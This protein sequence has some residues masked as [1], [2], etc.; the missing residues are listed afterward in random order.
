V[1]YNGDAS[2]LFSGSYDKTVRAWDIRARNAYAPIQVLDEFKDSVTSLV[3]SD[4][5][6]IAGCVSEI[7][8]A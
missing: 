3:V 5:E 2:V 7:V 6:I 1:R 8:V 4:H